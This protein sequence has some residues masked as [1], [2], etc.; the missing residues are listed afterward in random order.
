MTGMKK[1]VFSNFG[2]KLALALMFGFA[3][4]AHEGAYAPQSA[5]RNNLE[6]VSDFV[7]LG[8][9]VQRSVTCSG[10]QQRILEDG[11]LEATVQVR[12]REDRRIEVQANC[13]F[14]NEYGAAVD[15]TPFHTLILT[16]NAT[17]ALRFVSMNSQ[18]K[19]FTVRIREPH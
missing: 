2:S 13:V 15:E 6:T 4:C 7:L 1:H 17:E 3:G 16:E 9:R 10:V 12:N 14:K 18:A 11:R 8:P 19:K 5:N